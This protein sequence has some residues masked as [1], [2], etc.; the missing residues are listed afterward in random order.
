MHSQKLNRPRPELVLP[1]LHLQIP[2]DI[3]DRPRRPKIKPRPVRTTVYFGAESTSQVI[4]RR[5]TKQRL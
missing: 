2:L 3:P 1:G 4:I 5:A